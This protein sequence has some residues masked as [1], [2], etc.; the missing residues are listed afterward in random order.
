MSEASPETPDTL[1]KLV[2]QIPAVE[3]LMKLGYRYLQP[4]ETKALR[5]GRTSEVLLLP[6]LAEQLAKL[7]RVS[8]KGLERPFT[9]D[10]IQTAVAALRD[11][12]DEGLIPT[13]EKVFD[14]I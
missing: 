9:D 7:N 10:A 8:W 3:L 1:E 2:S 6:V 11:L 12:P 4:E 14:L 5:G 13:S